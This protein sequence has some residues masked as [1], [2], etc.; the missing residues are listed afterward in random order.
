MQKCQ[1]LAFSGFISF[2]PYFMIDQAALASLWSIM[3]E[4]QILLHKRKAHLIKT[5]QV[6]CTTHRAVLSP[7]YYSSNPASQ[8][9]GCISVSK[10]KTWV[11]SSV[12]FEPQKKR[13]I[14]GRIN[15]CLKLESST[16]PYG[17]HISIFPE[18][19]VKT[20]LQ[21]NVFV[22]LHP[23]QNIV[24]YFSTKSFSEKQKWKN[25]I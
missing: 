5:W 24:N 15:I 4:K 6:I 23:L 21:N 20:R 1:K 18:V 10:G 17:G 25:F 7:R 16:C 22:S 2:F 19:L 12:I 9:Q 14:S 13:R 11:S 3:R 8:V